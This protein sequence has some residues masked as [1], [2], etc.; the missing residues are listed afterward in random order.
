MCA[1]SVTRQG[2][3]SNNVLWRNNKIKLDEPDGLTSQKKL[4]QSV[5]FLTDGSLQSIHL[6]ISHFVSLWLFDLE[7]M[8]NQDSCWF[9]LSNPQVAK[10]LIASIGSE[11]YVSLP[12]GQLPDTEVGCPVPGGGHVLSGLFS[13]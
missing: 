10:H 7:S 11:T 6:T 4:D 13:V 3:G 5:H 1:A 12:K 2:T 9:C 8:E